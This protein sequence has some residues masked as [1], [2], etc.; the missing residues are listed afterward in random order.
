MD[1]E[2]AEYTRVRYKRSFLVPSQYDWR[3]AVEPYFKTHEDKYLWNT[4]LRLRI[5]TDSDTGRQVMKLHKMSGST[6][7]YLRTVSRVLLS[8]REYAA[9][10]VVRGDRLNKTR[11]YDN[12]GGQV[13]SIDVY[14]G[15]LEGLILC[16]VET[17]GLE[18]LT[19]LEPPAYVARE[20]TGD[21][22]F[23]GGVLCR[24]TRPELMDKLP[25]FG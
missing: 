3:S 9:L 24:T 8:G 22:F 18:E 12:H 10:D 5:Q 1:V 13:F 21:V 14:G 25:T 6:S 4:E 20:V 17:E 2:E 7:P 23:T 15:E 16:K 11:H 19:R